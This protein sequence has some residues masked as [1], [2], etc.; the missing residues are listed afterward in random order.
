MGWLRKTSDDLLLKK[1]VTGLRWTIAADNAPGL[2]PS[3]LDDPVGFLLKNPPQKLLKESTVRTVAIVIGPQGEFLLKR[4]K[5]RGVRE[6]LK[7]LFFP[8]KAHKEWQVARLAWRRGI[9]VPLPLA[10]AERRTVGV[11][12]D[13][14]LIIQ[15]ISPA[16]PLIELIPLERQG[17]LLLHAAR[18]MRDMHEA[19]LFHQDLHA[20][21]ILVEKVGTEK[22]K[23]YI[24]DL[25]RARFVRNIS[26]KKR[27]W[28]LAQFFYSLQRWLSPE[29]KKAFLQQYDEQKAILRHGLEA[30][31]REI[32]RQEHKIYRRHMKSRTKRCLKDSGGFYVDKKNG[33]RIWTRRGWKTEE[34]LAAVERHKAIV[35]EGREGI[36]KNDKRTAISLFNYKKTRICVKEY[37][38]KGTLQRLKE[39]FRRSKARR[40]WLMGNGLVVR[41][42]IGI[43]PD[44]LLEKRR[45][46]VLQKA[47]LIMGTPLGYVELDRYIVNAFGAQG[48]DDTRREAFLDAFAD[49][50]AHLFLHNIIHRDLKACN[51]MVREGGKGWDF[52]LVDMD[53]VRLDKKIRKRRLLKELVQLH[54]STPLMIDMKDRI[55]FLARYLQ[56][57]ETDD[58]RDT[59]KG[60]IKGARGRK[61]VYVAPEGVVITDADWKQACRSSGAPMPVT[62]KKL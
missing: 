51:I 50:M 49:F 19:G 29:G 23:L 15:A 48:N 61:L 22:K 52:G 27:L 2:P 4:Y 44:A 41:G 35:N 62:K 10:M 45:G 31:L 39:V 57:I 28:N 17:D 37:R 5:M 60:V 6:R 20:G 40:G 34:L 46:G 25:H 38:Y 55:R 8:S 59:M 32:E 13:A 53:D 26:K 30:G 42:I 47:F 21:N 9:P 54:T 11:L 33:W 1:G 58:I 3:L 56:L 36:I 16:T 7:Y 18:L 43:T 14:F 24:V 12:H